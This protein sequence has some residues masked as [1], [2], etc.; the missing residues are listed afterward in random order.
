MK[1][2]AYSIDILAIS[3]TQR[4]HCFQPYLSIYLCQVTHE[5]NKYC[6]THKFSDLSHI[7]LLYFLKVYRVVEFTEIAKDIIVIDKLVLS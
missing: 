6:I 5:E 4:N 3:S 1:F 7:T 2:K